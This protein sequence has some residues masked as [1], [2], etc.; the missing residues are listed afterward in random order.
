VD[1][2]LL[3]DYVGGALEGTPEAD[4]V[5]GLIAT[6]TAWRTAADSLTRALGAVSQDLQT[7]S[8]YGESMPPDVVSRFDDLFASPSFAVSP[9]AP[10]DPLASRKLDHRVAAPRRKSWRKWAVPVAAVIAAFGGFLVVRGFPSTT[11]PTAGLGAADSAAR[12]SVTAAGAP[13]PVPTISSGTNYSRQS[14]PLLAPSAAAPAAQPDTH[15]KSEEV[16]PGSTF[17]SRSSPSTSTLQACLEAVASVLPG[18][19]TLVD[20]AKFEDKPALVISI[21][22]GTQRWMFVAGPDCGPAGAAE[23]YRAPLK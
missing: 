6:S 16:L 1:H 10:K 19:P 4:R 22:S 7:F 14:L 17:F 23:I 13:G 18:T 5:A 8:G 15:N 3:A 2:D 21:T 11:S 12:E 20:Y 9:A